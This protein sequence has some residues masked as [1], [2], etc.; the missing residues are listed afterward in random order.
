VG[1]AGPPLLFGLRLWA[2]VCLTLYVAFWLE[3]ETPYWAATTAA[4][5]CQPSLGASLR[6]ASFRIIGTFISATAIIVLTASFPQNRVGFLLGLALWCALCGL[7]ASILQNFA[8]YAAALAG[9]T[10]AII[11]TRELGATG[12]IHGDVLML[13][14]NRVTEVCTGIVCAGLVL[15][16][17]DFGHARRRL[18]ATFAEITAAI[19]RGFYR[20]FAAEG[21]EFLELRLVRHGLIRRVAALGAVIDEAIGESTELRYRSRSLQ[22][23]VDGLFAALGGWRTVA[24]HIEH[25]SELSPCETEGVLSKLPELVHAAPSFASAMDWAANPP[26]LQQACRAAARGL[27]T[28]RCTTP[29]EQVVADYTAKTLLA[30]ARA[31]HGLAQL[32]N[33]AGPISRLRLARVRV[34]DWMPSIVN[35]LR[36]FV[37]LAAVGLFWI[38]TAWPSGAMAIAFAAIIVAKYGPKQDDAYAAANSF[39]FGTIL[40]ASLAAYFAFTVLPLLS[41]F[42]GLSL[43]LGAVLIPVGALAAQPWRGQLFGAAT[44]MFVPLLA[45][46]NHM[47][48]NAQQFYNSALA[49][50]VGVLFT[51]LAF[52]LLP[53]LSP[54]RRMQRLLWLTRRDL[55]RLIVRQKPA[56]QNEWENRIYGRLSVMPPQAE[57]RQGAQLA[58]AL[59]VGNE[60]IRLRRVA[61][62][63]GLRKETADALAALAGGNSAA[64]IAQLA[65]IDRSLA[66]MPDRQPEAKARLRARASIFVLTDAL[67]R[68]AGYF[69]AETPR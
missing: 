24:N 26:E 45:P 60:A 23:A 42:A 62:R 2:S 27:V 43:A 29:S 16:G 36:V 21:P 33:P 37:T 4:I 9:Y 5:V 67:A 20:S 61:N 19:S 51:V 17:T 65:T 52:R 18:A 30:M 32:S 40:A 48:Y 68:H 57:L 13:A 7:V 46:A 56:G 34:P 49:I 38:A 35:A 58:A 39:L 66:A 59:F 69:D 6:K 12:G 63:F 28:L 47:T 53:P 15:A 54:A 3:F 8:A 11:A 44:I 41:T 50:G 1:A 22:A 31:F 25:A 14:V 55:R 10:A 64:A